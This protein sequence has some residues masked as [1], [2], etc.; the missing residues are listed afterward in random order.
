MKLKERDVLSYPTTSRFSLGVSYPTYTSLPSLGLFLQLDSLPFPL[1]QGKKTNL[2]LV[3]HEASSP[4]HMSIHVSHVHPGQKT[5]EKNVGLLFLFP[6]M[7]AYRTLIVQKEKDTQT[8]CLW[9][10]KHMHGCVYIYICEYIHHV[11]I[12]CFSF[13]RLYA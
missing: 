8:W 6:T 13:S 5:V 10:H 9:Q 11:H 7:V 3:I 4:S 2:R 12:R 1:N